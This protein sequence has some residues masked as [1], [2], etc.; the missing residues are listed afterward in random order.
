[1]KKLICGALALSVLTSC[2]DAPPDGKAAGSLTTVV[3]DDSNPQ[4]R[5]VSPATVAQ[6][7][8]MAFNSARRISSSDPVK[9]NDLER[10]AVASISLP[11][12]QSHVEAL[13]RTVCTARLRIDVPVGARSIFSGE[14]LL[15]DIT[16]SMQPAADGS[17]LV[18]QVDSFGRIESTIGY[19][20]LSRFNV[21]TSRPTPPPPVA[22]PA[23]TPAPSSGGASFDCSKA[24]T[25]VE[26]LICDDPDLS[27]LDREMAALYAAA[28]RTTPG[29]ADIQL[30]WI[31]VRNK[32]A[33]ASCLYDAYD[34]RISQ[35]GG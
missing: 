26:M 8:A 2:N 3:A 9:M 27:A 1:M 18:Y 17:G 24:R 20:D 30:T 29:A 22:L 6:L 19:A 7:K 16:Y 35:L 12:L 5:C 21:S 25:N 4:T 31:K 33:N 14:E 13:D 34:E 28:R 23:A 10:D 32:C 11:L 15:A